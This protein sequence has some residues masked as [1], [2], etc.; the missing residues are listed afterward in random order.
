KLGDDLP[1]VLSRFGQPS[2]I[3]SEPPESARNS[4][5]HYVYPLS[6]VSFQLARDPGRPH[7][8]VVSMLIFTVK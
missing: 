1:S 8:H 3:L 5:R 4:D 2:F 7:P 6:Q